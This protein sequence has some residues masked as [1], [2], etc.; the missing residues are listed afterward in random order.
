MLSRRSLIIAAPVLA[1]PAIII[2]RTTSKSA[3][4]SFAA[5]SGVPLPSEVIAKG[6]TTITKFDHFTD[7]GTVDLNNTQAS[8][9]NW[10]TQSYF[11]GASY[12]NPAPPWTALSSSQVHVSNSILTI[13]TDISGFAE[14]LVSTVDNNVPFAQRPGPPYPGDASGPYYAVDP[15]AFKGWAFKNGAYID[16]AIKFDPV[17]FETM[18]SPWISV[19]SQ[20]QSFLTGA[21]QQGAGINN[22][23]YTELDFFEAMLWINPT[24]A[25]NAWDNVRPVNGSPSFVT[26][27]NDRVALPGI[28]W[29][30]WNV[31]G[32]FWC[33]MNAN[34]GTG[35]VHRYVNGVLIPD[36]T[37]TWQSGDMFSN[38]DAQTNAMILGAGVNHPLQVD[39][40]RVTQRSTSDIVI[41]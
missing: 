36:V 26:N 17:P 38:L 7:P 11:A 6:F 40:V 24:F 34:S 15:S 10:Y 28:D 33:P 41:Q 20:P 1:A 9:F 3:W 12:A 39:W 2:P 25:L 37:V 14:G 19:W 35:F 16:Y 31:L 13:D 8:G 22:R 4:A 21:D 23:I 27:S 29:T 18:I 32:T 5:S 30:Q